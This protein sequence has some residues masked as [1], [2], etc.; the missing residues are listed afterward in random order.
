MKKIK[1]L[2]LAIILSLSFFT[3]SG[4]ASKQFSDVASDRFSANAINKMT[5]LKIVNGYEDGTFKPTNNITRA[6]LAKIVST[7]AFLGETPNMPESQNLV[8][9]PSSHWAADVINYVVKQGYMEPN[10]SNAFEPNRNVTRGEFANVLWNM[11]DYVIPD[12]HQINFV[13]VPKSSPYYESVRALTYLKITSGVSATEFSPNQ[14]LTR[15]QIAVFFDRE[16]SLD[17][18][19]ASTKKVSLTKYHTKGDKM[20]SAAKF[21]EMIKPLENRQLNIFHCE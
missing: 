20:L 21:E 8:D 9:V 6:E 5:E 19:I 2:L 11:R 4:S 18:G 12:S 3:M 14:P 15:E 17:S 13:D 10:S 7:I 1:G 16:G